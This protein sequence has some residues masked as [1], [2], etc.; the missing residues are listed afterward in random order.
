MTHA[1]VHGCVR[2]CVVA[3]R[4]H[5]RAVARD[6]DVDVDGGRTEWAMRV[7]VGVSVKHDLDHRTVGGP[8]GIPQRGPVGDPVPMERPTDP[9]QS[10]RPPDKD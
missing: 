5:D 9:V 8:H 6:L 7:Y 4:V 1:H 3:Q 10:A 2:I